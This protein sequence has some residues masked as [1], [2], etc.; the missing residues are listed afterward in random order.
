M[1]IDRRSLG[2]SLL[3]AGLA[4]AGASHTG[5]LPWLAL[6][7]ICRHHADG[8]AGHCP[9]CLPALLLSLAGAG[10]WLTQGPA[11]KAAAA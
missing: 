11:P 6:E 3:A 4:L 10:L 5:A 7:P 2:L 1:S 8:L 9:A